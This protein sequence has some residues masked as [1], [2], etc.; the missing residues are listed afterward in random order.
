MTPSTTKTL[1]LE[2]SVEP[3]PWKERTAAAG[4]AAEEEEDEDST[5]PVLTEEQKALK[6]AWRL[7]VR[8]GRPSCVM[9]SEPGCHWDTAE[10]AHHGGVRFF[11]E[12]IVE[13]A[14]HVLCR[15][16]PYEKE[17]DGVKF[18]VYAVNCMGHTLWQW[19]VDYWHDM[20]SG[21]DASSN[22][23]WEDWSGWRLVE[24]CNSWWPSAADAVQAGAELLEAHPG[25]FVADAR[26][27]MADDG[28]HS[29]ATTFSYVKDCKHFW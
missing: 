25:R 18:K 23:A 3:L 14:R 27:R 1:T 26:S 22:R 11:D 7:D 12:N 21:S 4:W 8:L 15:A 19:K 29:K 28:A 9:V 17:L 2:F 5:Y 13:V 6:W 20:D 10:E 16:R 24:N